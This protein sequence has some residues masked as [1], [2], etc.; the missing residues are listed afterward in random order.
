ML[1]K[2]QTSLYDQMN[3]QSMQQAKEK[4]WD[5]RHHIGA[6]I[7]QYIPQTKLLDKYIQDYNKNKETLNNS[8]FLASATDKIYKQKLSFSPVKN[9]QG[10]QS[11]ISPVKKI[12]LSKNDSQGNIILTNIDLE[13]IH[14]TSDTNFYSYVKKNQEFE[15][16]SS[17]L[18]NRIN[19][20]FDELKFEQF[21]R[22][23][24]NL[25]IQQQNVQTMYS[26]L[27][28][29]INLIEARQSPYQLVQQVITEREKI[30]RS[31][32]DSVEQLDSTEQWE[33]DPKILQIFQKISQLREFT[34]QV[35]EKID[36][37][38]KNLF[39]ISN[40]AQNQQ[41]EIMEHH[42]TFFFG[43]ENYL[44]KIFSDNTFLQK[45]NLS[46]KIP[47][48][49]KHDPFLVFP[50]KLIIEKSVNNPVFISSFDL[51]QDLRTRIINVEKQL[52]KEIQY[53][54]ERKS[55]SDLDKFITEQSQN[56]QKLNQNTQANLK[57]NN[58]QAENQDLSKR[59]TFTKH[60]NILHRRNQT[61]QD[62]TNRLNKSEYLIQSNATTGYDNGKFKP[63]ST[64][65]LLKKKG[66]LK[67]L[68]GS[69]V[70]INQQ[71]TQLPLLNQQS[72][73]KAVNK[74]FSTA[75]DKQRGKSVLDIRRHSRDFIT[76]NTE[77]TQ[78][79]RKK[80]DSKLYE[81][82]SLEQLEVTE[83][84][85]QQAKPKIER[86][87][88]VNLQEINEKGYYTKILPEDEPYYMKLASDT[89]YSKTLK[90]S[91]TSSPMKRRVFSVNQTAANTK[92]NFCN[93]QIYNR[94]D[95]STSPTNKQQDAPV[96]KVIRFFN[97]D[98]EIQQANNQIQTNQSSQ[99]QDNQTTAISNIDDIIVLGQL[100]SQEKEIQILQ[101][102]QK[103]NAKNDKISQKEENNI[104]NNKN[105]QVSNAK[106]LSIIKLQ[107]N[108]LVQTLNE[109][110]SLESPSKQNKK[111]DINQLAI[112]K[113]QDGNQN[114]IKTS[115]FQNQKNNSANRNA[116]LLQDQSYNQKKQTQPVQNKLN[117]ESSN[118]KSSFSPSKNAN[119]K[120]ESLI[121]LDES[122]S[123]NS[124]LKKVRSQT[125]LSD[126]N[127]SK[128][129]DEPLPEARSEVLQNGKKKQV[130]SS[131]QNIQEGGVSPLKKSQSTKKLDQL[132]KE[133]KSATLS[134][135]KQQ[136]SSQS[137]II[138][139]KVGSYQFVRQ[140]S[141]GKHSKSGIYPKRDNA[142]LPNSKGEELE[143]I[144]G[145]K[146]FRSLIL[147]KQQ[148]EQNNNNN[149]VNN[150]VKLNIQDKKQKSSFKKAALALIQK[151]KE[152][153]KAQLEAEQKQK[154]YEKQLKNNQEYN[155]FLRREQEQKLQNI[156]D[157]NLEEA[158]TDQN[159][160][161]FNTNAFK[162]S[163][164]V[165]PISLKEEEVNEIVH[166]Y[167][168][169]IHPFFSGLFMR[170]AF[171]LIYQLKNDLN[172]NFLQAVER[173]TM[174]VLGL[175]VVHPY[176]DYGQQKGPFDF[177]E[178]SPQKSSDNNIQSDDEN[179]LKNEEEEEE[180]I[181][182]NDD[183]N[184]IFYQS[185]YSQ[186]NAN[187]SFFSSK[188][189]FRQQNKLLSK[190]NSNK[191]IVRKIM[192]IDHFSCIDINM[193][194]G[195]FSLFT[196]YIWT[197]DVADR[198]ETK[199]YTSPLLIPLQEKIEQMITASSYF[200]TKQL[201]NN[202]QR[203]FA[204][205]RDE[206]KYP[207]DE[208]LLGDSN[209]GKSPDQ[210]FFNSF[211]MVSKQE[212]PEN[213]I[214]NKS[215]YV[216]NGG[217]F[218][219]L[220]ALSHLFKEMYISDV[221]KQLTEQNQHEKIKQLYNLAYTMRI[222]IR[223]KKIFSDLFVNQE[224]D[225][226]EKMNI[227]VENMSFLPTCEYDDNTN[228]KIYMNTF[229][230]K[231][232]LPHACHTVMTNS[233]QKEV[234]YIRISN[235]SNQ[236][237]SSMASTSN[238]TPLVSAL[239]YSRTTSNPMIQIQTVDT[240]YTLFFLQAD[241]FF[242]K[243]LSDIYL[244][245]HDFFKESDL[246][247]PTY[248][249]IWLPQFS[250]NKPHIRNDDFDSVLSKNRVFSSLNFS[251]KLPDYIGGKLLYQ[252]PSR[253]KSV[254]VSPPF[255]FGIIDNS[256][257]IHMP[258]QPIFSCLID[259]KDVLYF[260]KNH[261]NQCLLYIDKEVDDGPIQGYPKITGIQ[262]N[263]ERT[264]LQKDIR[265]QV[266]HKSLK[267]KTESQIKE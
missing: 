157:Q 79:L 11:S 101:Q 121:F 241:D 53:E 12:R 45:S 89:S 85:I 118:D 165:N 127:S 23:Y 80:R 170:D 93:E 29:E 168:K 179:F 44:I 189:T 26:I 113:Q 232:N 174:K 219:F 87:C 34:I 48:S 39:M 169:K 28:K 200:F 194:K 98:D 109:Q 197:H 231:L 207:I 266:L 128:I 158:L 218:S 119:G 237:D 154:D 97:L 51:S 99:N 217:K 73:N 249:T 43:E 151:Q 239:V 49:S 148:E 180:D 140:K 70:Q 81:N 84:Q 267:Q 265:S 69:L 4:E 190:A 36:L 164:Q 135:L 262:N 159:Q 163:I 19:V 104:K 46:Q 186:Q 166:N 102:G 173:R 171:T 72:Q 35:I 88:C 155:D 131:I 215:L 115:L 47:L 82:V 124:K 144:E 33:N 133:Q 240:K 185:Q 156:Q 199:F 152:E 74:S 9:R 103:N 14:N 96:K 178:D 191:N 243:Q 251:F 64:I 142:N 175:L 63:Q 183:I 50:T 195:L 177:F 20:L 176:F 210:L 141:N 252:E 125:V 1:P 91:N 116:S 15:E 60:F 100:E 62:Q 83:D 214:F 75:A 31:L 248:K 242:E 2:I 161:P 224:F 259:E 114:K 208:N 201:Q 65:M 264:D 181:Y 221:L 138:P 21:H 255:I 108:G 188:T 149:D 134:D 258:N 129:Q 226:I 172:F 3:Q 90:R 212:I 68:N 225:S 59:S 229:S 263:I 211:I 132:D 228:N 238:S 86:E 187:S 55:Q 223:K 61:A 136:N 230:L 107:N 76:Q 110:E 5:Q 66:S 260:D 162:V 139:Q 126:A 216:D 8:I 236:I 193:F 145:E 227:A 122:N 6:K 198:I 57:M 261:T 147:N 77:M 246:K 38:R 42:L 16:K 192:I 41:F 196:E 18:L 206:E 233:Q 27:K 58:N 245:I 235:N 37:W 25:F 244:Y 204:S 167:F 209:L 117:E 10:L 202:S 213:K 112:P 17:Q 250:I 40:Q 123:Q 247:E 7:P 24:F 71:D 94:G 56:G 22:D 106:S 257:D 13:S 105:N 92:T 153:K 54:S 205:N 137:S 160:N 234:L 253:Q 30:L 220:C 120:K 95:S 222:N 182:D 78:L 130:K 52:I 111:S 203:V 256:F 150:A 184:N 67:N 146:M 143:K 254:Y 32:T